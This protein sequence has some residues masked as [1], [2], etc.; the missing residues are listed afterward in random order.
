MTL[1]D[2]DVMEGAEAP[3]DGLLHT[4][5]NTVVKMDI[6]EQGLSGQSFRKFSTQAS[7]WMSGERSANG[8]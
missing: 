7:P 4:Q 5:D 6:L 3:Y 2:G 1:E 8:P